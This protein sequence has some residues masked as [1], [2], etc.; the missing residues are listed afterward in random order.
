MAFDNVKTTKRRRVAMR[1]KAIL[2]PAIAVFAAPA[3]TMPGATGIRAEEIQVADIP[4][5]RLNP[6]RTYSDLRPSTADPIADFLAT[7]G[8]DHHGVVGDGEEALAFTPVASIKR[9]TPVSTSDI[10]TLGLRYALKFLDDGDPAAATAAAYAMP[11]PI[12]TK[13]IDW[14]VAISGRDDVP[15]PHIA[16]V[17]RKLADWPGQVLLQIRFEQALVREKPPAKTVVDA[18][19]GRTP[20]TDKGLVLLAESYL[21]LGRKAEAARVVGSYWREQRFG[22]ESE[23][24]LRK[25]VGGLISSAD[26][27]ARMDR[28][29]YEEQIS[30]GLRNAKYLDKGQQALAAAVAA[31]ETNKNID[32]ALAAVPANVRRDP[33]YA[34]ARVQSLRRADKMEEAAKLLLTA[35]RDPA[36]IDGD[37][38]WIER[39]I[40]SRA[41][42]DEGDAKM[43]YRVAAG[44]SAESPSTI[45]E[46]EFH[47][48]WF[49]LEFLGDPATAKKHFARILDVSSRPLSVSRADYWLGRAAEKQGR[50]SEAVTYYKRAG[51]HPTTYYGQLALASLGVKTL[52]IAPQPKADA[53]TRARFESRELVQVIKRLDAANRGDRNDIFYRKLAEE[54]DDPVEI[55][56]LAQMAEEHGG[57][58]F[59]LQIG[60]IASYRGLQVDATAFPLSAIPASAHTGDVE[61]PLVF[62]IAR[63]ESAFNPAAVSGA[64][65]RGLLQLMPATAKMMA[66]AAGLP[67]SQSRLT[68]DPA[69]N[70]ALGAAFLARLKASF[71]GSFIMTFAGYNAGPSRVHAWVEKYGDPRDPNVDAVNWVERIPFT[72]T[73]N[74]VQ[75]VMENLQVYRA[76]L[77]R[78]ALTIQTDLKQG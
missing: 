40:V 36:K 68:T 22:A 49:A 32:K 6:Q 56:L 70:A 35:P 3:L 34:F 71:G 13:V 15:A 57:H 47:A 29:L 78:P 75:R 67:Y 73:R 21:A 51:Q 59:A 10:N 38:W 5:P 65:A 7:A 4:L 58:Q 18:L 23:S 33:L 8:E 54:L 11:N 1:G 50:R 12:D 43:A 30:A 69:Y 28:L 74:Y 52:P 46:A 2:I 26:Y 76:R 16:E 9:S 77:G 19:T 66:K 55:E 39:R 45:A 72:E 62:A 48:G 25:E 41:L 64:G 14:L 53:A 27:K 42:L 37:A 20:E 17:W 60:K 63:Q 24:L 61:K 44:H 31:S